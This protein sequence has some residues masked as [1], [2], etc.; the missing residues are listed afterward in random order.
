MKHTFLLLIFLTLFT[1]CS[2]IQ[3]QQTQNAKPHW[4]Q[5][6]FQNNIVGAVGFSSIHFNGKSAQRKLALTRALEELA[7]QANVDIS[8]ITV[9]KESRD[10]FSSR[11]SSSTQT[12]A[13]TDVSSLSARIEATW[14]DPKN[15][16]IYIW[17]R[18]NN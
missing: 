17:V 10:G 7:F 4:I 1:S 12:V 13:K 8:S 3:L 2:S 15:R 16:D 5:F 11:T 14:S 9:V 18:L 6:P